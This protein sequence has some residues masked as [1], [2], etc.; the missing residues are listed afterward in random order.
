MIHHSEFLFLLAN[1]LP[2][3]DIYV[4]L[5]VQL[6]VTHQR[7][8]PLFARAIGVDI[9]DCRAY[10]REFYQRTTD[11]F[12]SKHLASLAADSVDLIFIDANHERQQVLRDFL[13]SLFLVKPM[14]GLIVIHDTYPGAESFLNP[15]QCDNAWMAAKDIRKHNAVVESVTIPG[16]MHGLTVC[17][18]LG[19][20]GRHL[21]WKE[22]S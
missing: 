20:G 15:D 10:C 16:V 3:R 11:D 7:L 14:T 17:R 13:N 6:G 9:A 18:K 1:V 22:G 4:E 19:N 21:H 2:A 5:G 8:A 12:F